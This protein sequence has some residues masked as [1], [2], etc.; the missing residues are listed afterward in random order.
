MTAMTWYAVTTISS[1]VATH[2]IIPVFGF[3]YNF[4]KSGFYTF[5]LQENADLC[6]NYYRCHLKRLVEQAGGDLER[7]LRGLS[8][9]QVIVHFAHGER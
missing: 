9:I 1:L 3:I 6:E 5:L 4:S 2:C 7:I 8:I